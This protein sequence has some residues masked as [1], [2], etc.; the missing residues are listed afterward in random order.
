MT[1]LF[2]N[3]VGE[4]SGFPNVLEAAKRFADAPVVVL[5][6]KSSV[7]HS[8]NTVFNRSFRDSANRFLQRNPVIMDHPGNM[9]SIL[10]WLIAAE[11]AEESEIEWPMLVLDWDVMV[12]QP[13]KEAWAPFKQFDIGCGCHG[14][15]NWTAP[16]GV[17][18]CALLSFS[19]WLMDEP[20]LPWMQDM[21]LWQ[22]FYNEQGGV[23]TRADIATIVNG[24]TWDTNIGLGL[25]RFKTNEDGKRIVWVDGRPHFEA[26]GGNLV[27][28]NCVHC[29]GTYKT[30][31]SQLAERAGL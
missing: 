19:T 29:W 26:I 1:L 8:S 20:I 17:S 30:K 13:I 27:K 9:P 16:Y 3:V 22:K 2:V 10:R 24:A 12:F 6:P 18:K 25:D 21:Y 23:I 15:G 4:Y 11:F 7:A 28:A 5:E 14:D 31:T